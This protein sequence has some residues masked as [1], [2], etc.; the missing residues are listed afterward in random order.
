MLIVILTILI[1]AALNLFS[2]I[3]ENTKVMSLQRINADL[4][5]QL[6]QMHKNIDQVK[7]QIRSLEGEDDELRMIAGLDTIGRD[8]RQ[9]GVGGPAPAYSNEVDLFPKETHEEI[10]KARGLIDQLE[11]KIKLLCESREEIDQALTKNENE[12]NHLPT[13]RPVRGGWISARFGKR[14]DPFTDLLTPHYGL[15]LAVP[16]GT[17][18]FATGE[19]VVI[20]INWNYKK[21]KG[22]GRFVVIDHGYGRQTKYAHLSKILV[23]VG[24]NVSRWQKIGESGETGKS[25]GPH[26]HYEVLSWSKPVD[27]LKYFLE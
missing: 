3:F 14:V 8:M 24:Q 22:Y 21:N 27:P 15:D 18:V 1:G 26:L 5:T 16:V 11:R 17:P 13:I 12:I 10:L 9:A 25:T 19:G 23:R 20:K 4:L 2:D 6:N 7:M